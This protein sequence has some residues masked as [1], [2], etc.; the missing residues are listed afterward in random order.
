[1]IPTQPYCNTNATQ[2]KATAPTSPASAGLALHVW[3]FNAFNPDAAA[4]A[5]LQLFDAAGADVAVGTTVPTRVL[6][7]PPKG[8][9]DTAR[10]A[11]MRFAS[12]RMTYAVTA[13]PTGAGAPATPCLLSLDYN[14]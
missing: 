9:V 1:L 2:T 10:S 11:P 3:N 7:L 4:V 5:Y 13:T 6:A 8:G 12:G 14:Y